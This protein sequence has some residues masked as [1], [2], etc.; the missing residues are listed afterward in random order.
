LRTAAII[1]ALGVVGAVSQ[2]ASASLAPTK[3]PGDLADS[4]RVRCGRLAVPLDAGAVGGRQVS[5]FAAVTPALGVRRGTLIVLAGGPG[6]SATTDM[7]SLLTPVE[8]VNKWND[9]VAFDVRGTGRSDPVRCAG[10]QA[11]PSLL[12]AA[13]LADCTR[14]ANTDLNHYTT[15]DHVRDLDAVRDALGEDRI[16]LYGVSY[17]ARLALAYAS[18]H[19]NRVSW[20]LLDSVVPAPDAPLTSFAAMRRVLR[21]R[22]RALCPRRDVMKT[23][24]ALVLQL[25][26]SP[27]HGTARDA[28]GMPRSV[29]LTAA[30]LYDLILAG[31]GNDALRAAIPPAAVAAR[32][33]DP[34]ALLRLASAAARATRPTTS[35]S[36]SSAGLYAATT[37]GDSVAALG[38]APDVASRVAAARAKLEAGGQMPLVPFDSTT[39]LE[40]TPLALCAHWPLFPLPVLHPGPFPS[41][42]ALVI[43]GDEDLRA[44]IESAKAIAARLPRGALLRVRQTGHA[45]L[46]SELE[47]EC[48]RRTARTFVVTLRVSR[49]DCPSSVR[50]SP[51]GIPPQSLSGLRAVTGVSRRVGKVLRAVA[52]TLDDAAVAQALD[53]GGLRHGSITPRRRLRSYEYVRGLR[54]SGHLVHDRAFV[55]K[56]SGAAHGT[57]VV[58]RDGH[59]RGEVNKTPIDIRLRLTWGRDLFA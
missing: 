39:A 4:G 10:L 16:A 29:T 19:P 47:R 26:H 11:H 34:A 31:D 54:I 6:D 43:A 18:L 55:L 36:T 35:P 20:L 12:S 7:G 27:V 56:L 40:V 17:G 57:V 15:A 14:F 51:V 46:Q 50:R 13:D 1:G 42:P 5:L 8:A 38:A 33:G 21:K 24:A 53:V 58:R 28:R 37:C 25:R 48:A 2:P 22:C 41:V 52:L 23:I 30:G 45:V 9:I 59:L 49:R 44:P 32:R 3:C